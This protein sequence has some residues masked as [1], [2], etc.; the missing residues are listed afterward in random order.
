MLKILPFFAASVLLTLSSHAQQAVIDPSTVTSG[1]SSVTASDG[2]AT[3][4]AHGPADAVM[5]TGGSFIGINSSIHTHPAVRDEDGL[6]PADEYF[7]LQLAAEVGLSQLCVTWTRAEVTIVGFTANPGIVVP[8]NTAT[9]FDPET[10]TLVIQQAWTDGDIVCYSFL[11]PE[12]SAGQTLDILPLDSRAAGGQLTIAS[13]EYTQLDETGPIAVPESYLRH[14]SQLFK[15]RWPNN[16]TVNIIVYGDATS[17]GYNEAGQPNVLSAYPHFLRGLLKERYP[18]AV[19][20]VI[21]AG[22]FGLG[23]SDA[24]SR[25]EADVL[26]LDPDLVILDFGTTHAA[27]PHPA[28]IP[29]LST[30]AAHAV[31]SGLRVLLATPPTSSTSAGDALS[32]EIRD[33]AAEL[34]VGLADFHAALNPTASAGG[35]WFANQFLLEDGHWQAAK[36]I[37]RWF[38]DNP[39]SGFP[40]NTVTT[41]CE[42]KAPSRCVFE[43]QGLAG[44][45][46][47]LQRATE[48]NRFWSTIDIFSPASNAALEINLTSKLLEDTH[49]EG[50]RFFRVRLY[51]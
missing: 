34:D 37:I 24:A 40:E 16:R 17:L 20:N 41:S 21:S 10:G 9:E 45:T 23:V 14:L 4:S 15:A 18:Y 44:Q 38:P 51:R 29:S 28:F 36:E 48:L 47:L 22:T 12:A 32:T 1:E 42:I 31:Q 49:P 33:L 43:L 3:L 8:G 39:L 25:F 7:R 19:I 11:N 35:D 2:L 27:D 13:I 26:S 5:Q 6:S 30:M 50:K 46:V